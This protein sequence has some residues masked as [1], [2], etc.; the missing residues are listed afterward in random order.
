MHQE[1]EHPERVSGTDIV[2]SDFG[3]IA[4]GLGAAHQCITRTEEFKPALLAAFKH[5]GPTVLELM[6]DPEQISTRTTI[7]KLRGG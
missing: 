6:T 3:Q 4:R 7:S 1:R 5:D 2:T